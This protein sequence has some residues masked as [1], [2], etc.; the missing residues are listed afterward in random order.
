MN[1]NIKKII[2]DTIQKYIILI[3]T[4]Y[5]IDYEELHELFEPKLTQTEA[6]II[7]RRFWVKYSSILVLRKVINY[8]KKSLTI[9]DLQDFSN[10]CYSIS[11]KLKGEGC[12][13]SSG[14]FIDMLICELFT[15]KLKNFSEYHKGESDMKINNIEFSFKKITGKSIIA[16]DWSKNK[17]VSN[18]EKFSSHIILLNLKTEKW[19]KNESE[20]L[21]G[22]YIIDK[23]YCKKYIIL[24][25]NNKTNSLIKQKEV[26]KLLKRSEYQQLFIIIP[27]MNH[28]LNFTISN[29]FTILK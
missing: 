19:T 26:Y 20:I 2:Q 28:E 12:G 18:K 6:Q 9:N 14:V 25:S 13:L 22:L 5:K 7:I 27:K 17:S 1:T 8:I 23:K 29:S 21:S 16:L 10:K 3:S 24:S 15:N 4:K 11:K